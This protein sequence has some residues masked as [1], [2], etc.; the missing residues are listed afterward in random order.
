MG[1]L[2]GK[3]VLIR[4]TKLW[5]EEQAQVVEEEGL[6][7]AADRALLRKIAEYLLGGA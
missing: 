6:F 4:N 2:S 7:T 5:A 3:A 1:L